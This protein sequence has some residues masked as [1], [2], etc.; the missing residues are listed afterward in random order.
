[1]Y[2]IVSLH[3]T[4]TTNTQGE[5]KL[6]LYYIVSLHQTT[7]QATRKASGDGCIISFLYIKPQLSI[8]TRQ[9]RRVVL[10]RFSTSN[11]N[12]ITC[13]SVMIKLYY[14]VS[15]HQTTTLSLSWTSLVCCII[16]F[17]Y[18]KPQQWIDIITKFMVVLYRFS[19]SNHNNLVMKPF[20]DG[21]YYIVSLHQ[22]T[23]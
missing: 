11:H 8:V 21:L 3:Q 22:T 19:T 12:I 20:M 16:S 5:L 13:N 17:L 7:T 6:G 4:T 10:Y 9:K 15:L 14:I 1:M 2:Y 23:T 18:I